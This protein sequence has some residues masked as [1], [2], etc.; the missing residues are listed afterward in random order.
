M[1]LT[2]AQVT[3]NFLDLYQHKE[4]TQQA[5]LS[6]LSSLLD[7]HGSQAIE[8]ITTTDLETYLKS[9]NSLA[10]STQ[11]R[12]RTII[13]SL[14]NYAFQESYILSNP[15]ARLPVPTVPIAEITYFSPE[16]IDRLYS[17]LTASATPEGDRLH[18]LVRLLHRT[19]AK[20]SEIL[21]ANLE[22]LDLDRR[23][24]R[25]I[26]Y[27][28]RLRSLVYSE[29]VPPVLSRYLDRHRHRNHPALFTFVKRGTSEVLRLPYAI[30]YRD[31][32]KLVTPYPD[33]KSF[34]INDLRH[35]FAIER[36]GI[37]PIDRL[38]EWMGHE[39]IKMTLRYK[40]NI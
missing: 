20:V 33:L 15:L 13:A 4:V 35:T 36:V 37:V 27:R 24:I 31:W 2:L 28:N 29:D 38:Q 32:Q 14:F 17:L 40:N 21:S 26:G 12:H 30:V 18:A 16:Q 5:Y 10:I 34:R 7:R 22:D 9:L 39:D 3:V 25:V 1:S 6:V 11:K 8:E 23:E 19:G